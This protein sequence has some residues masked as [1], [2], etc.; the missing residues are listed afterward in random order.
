[1]KGGVYRMLT[2]EDGGHAVWIKPISEIV[3]LL[4]L[5]CKIINWK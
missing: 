4:Q 3:K 2:V 1:M 5:C